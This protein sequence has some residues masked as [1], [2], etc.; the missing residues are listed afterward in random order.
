MIIDIDK[1]NSVQSFVSMITSDW[2]DIDAMY[3]DLKSDSQTNWTNFWN[4]VDNM[5]DIISNC[6]GHTSEEFLKSWE[7]KCTEHDAK[8]MGYLHNLG[9]TE[10]TY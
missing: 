9:R 4:I 1:A 8:I 6:L 10:I 7:K 5:I 3:Y 2:F